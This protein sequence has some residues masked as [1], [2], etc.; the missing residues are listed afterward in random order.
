[1]LTTTT[2]GRTRVPAYTISSP[3][4]LW[5]RWAKNSPPVP[6]LLQAQQVLALPYAE[7]VGHPVTGSYPAPLPDP[8]THRFCHAV[9]Q[10]FSEKSGSH[11]K[12][13]Q[14]IL[15]FNDATFGHVRLG[16]LLTGVVNMY[17][18]SQYVKYGCYLRKISS[19]RSWKIRYTLWKRCLG[20][21]VNPRGLTD[22]MCNFGSGGRVTSGFVLCKRYVV[23][24][25]SF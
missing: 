6:H 2:D 20:Y 4:S 10:L 17:T 21:L 19:L 24:L 7:V 8:T 13:Q 9:A 14:S 15:I 12:V 1:M 25:F 16:T 3:M 5:L 23:C 11:Q 22:V 18:S